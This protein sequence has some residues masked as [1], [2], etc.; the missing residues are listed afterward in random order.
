MGS[1]AGQ[2]DRGTG[3]QSGHRPHPGTHAG[4]RRA[5][6]P[7]THRAHAQGF[8]RKG[9]RSRGWR[10]DDAVPTEREAG[11]GAAVAGMAAPCRKRSPAPVRT[12]TRGRAGPRRRS[13]S[14]AQSGRRRPPPGVRPARLPGGLRRQSGP[15]ALPSTLQACRA[16]QT[17]VGRTAIIA[18]NSTPVL[19]RGDAWQIDRNNSREPGAPVRR[20]PSLQS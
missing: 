5:R 17:I 18:V 8:H 12:C 13:G 10:P 15:V 11:A 20:T 1:G 4:N 19:T 16:R 6:V 2:W 7:H 3:R 14:A 9:D